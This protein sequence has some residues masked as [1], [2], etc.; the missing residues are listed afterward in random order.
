MKCIIHIFYLSDSVQE[1]ELRKKARLQFT[2]VEI[3][4]EDDG[5]VFVAKVYFVVF[6]FFYKVFLIFQNHYIRSGMYNYT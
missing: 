2:F 5:N 3:H 6:F 4:I 1:Y